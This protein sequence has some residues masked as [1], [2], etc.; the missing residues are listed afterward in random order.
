MKISVTSK[1]DGN[2]SWSLEAVDTCPGAVR[3]DA[4]LQ[5]KAESGP[6]PVLAL[7]DACSGCYAR[8]GNYLRPNVRAARAH[9]KLD[10][11]RDEWEDEMVAALTEDEYFRWFDSGDMYAI[12]LARK[13]YAVMRRTPWCKHWLPTRM[14]K[15]AKFGTV[16]RAMMA[17]PN[18]MVR[19]S[20]DS[21]DGT[22]VPGVHG[23][24]IIDADQPTPEG[25]VRCD[26][27]TRG[28]V[29]GGCRAC[30]S[31]DI[32]VIAYPGHSRRM[33][34]LIRLSRA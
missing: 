34:K 19:P 20:S 11:Q 21:I 17:L 5:Y 3:T 23:S 2:R 15:F 4:D 32:A 8:D 22:F 18:V 27:Y 16:I 12:E 13:M 31:K 1:L 28:G 9:N 29:C 30:W 14:H 26:A 7:V 10:W 24:T 25:T 6:G 33:L